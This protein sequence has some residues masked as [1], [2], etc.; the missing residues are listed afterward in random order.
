MCA[1]LCDGRTDARATA[2]VY[3]CVHMPKEV[4]EKEK[5]CVHTLGKSVGHWNY[6]SCA[7]KVCIQ[8][9][10]KFLDLGTVTRPPGSIYARVNWSVVR[11][12][13]TRVQGAPAK[14]V[15]TT[16]DFR[17]FVAKA[18]HRPYHASVLWYTEALHFT[19]LSRIYLSRIVEKVPKNLS[20]YAPD[21]D[22][23][24]KQQCN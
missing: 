12:R 7:P 1:C 24:N 9:S 2:A 14:L 22:E 13:C 8:Q 3:V 21:Q 5:M 10:E 17:A 15:S 18:P 23:G 6:R 19:S 20:S 11:D 4:Y 16:M